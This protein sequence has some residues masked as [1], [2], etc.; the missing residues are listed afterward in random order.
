MNII[1]KAQLKGSKSNTKAGAWKYLLARLPKPH[2]GLKMIGT[3]KTRA[4]SHYPAPYGR[5]AKSLADY[6]RMITERRATRMA[7]RLGYPTRS[8]QWAWYSEAYEMHHEYIRRCTATLSR[9][10]YGA[11]Y[12]TTGLAKPGAYNAAYW[13]AWD[14]IEQ[15]RK[16]DLIDT[17]YDNIEWDRKGRADGEAVHHEMYDFAPGAVLVCVRRTEGTPYG[18]KT[19]SKT[20]YLVEQAEETVLCTLTAKPVARWAK[21][22]SDFGQVIAA[23][24]GEIKISPITVTVPGYKLLRVNEDGTLASVWDGSPWQLGKRRTEAVKKGHNGGLYYYRD[25]AKCLEAASRNVVFADD[26]EHHRLAVLRVETAGKHLE[27]VAGKYAASHITPLDIIAMT[28]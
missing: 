10:G 8:E 21:Q 12:C 14:L 28:I 20:Y 4:P 23:V 22:S 27:Y 6:R 18:V 13:Q 19:L 1:T 5:D 24:S 16:T 2:A 15:A 3:G 7:A 26:M 25:L 11:I 9:D 17:S